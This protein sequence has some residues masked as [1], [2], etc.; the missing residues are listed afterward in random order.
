MSKPDILVVDDRANML[1]LLQKVL[2]A[3]ANVFMAQSGA[4]AIALLESQPVA[5]VVCDLRLPDISGIDVLRA[6]RRLQPAAEF[7]LMTAY[8][9]VP[10]AVEAMRQGAYDYV[11]KPFDPGHL[12]GIVQRALSAAAH[13]AE[14]PGGE[15]QMAA[16]VAPAD[17]EELPPPVAGES[18][19]SAPD[20]SSSGLLAMTWHEAMELRRRETAR[21]YLQAV[22]QQ[23]SGR[24]S[25]AAA[26]AGVERESFYRLLRRYGVQPK[27]ST[28][29]GQSAPST[30]DAGD[31]ATSPRVE[32][33]DDPARN[34][35]DSSRDPPSSR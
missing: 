31:A 10:T 13:A 34:A 8:A 11:T 14:R 30:D 5:A 12:R 21:Q 3:G 22:I 2:G 25:D 16:P 17:T 26:H 33:D 19:L 20:G 23:Y 4:D 6:C 9:S 7:V 32:G 1:Q 27:A 24:I 35:L 15:V 18:A 29:S 28:A